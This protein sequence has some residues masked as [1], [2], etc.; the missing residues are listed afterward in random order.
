MIGRK[1]KSPLTNRF[2]KNFG[3]GKPMRK[4]LFVG[5]AL[6]LLVPY[7]G[8]TLAASVTITGSGGNT[9]I[10]FGQG[11]QVAINCDTSIIT[12][13]NQSWDSNSSAFTVGAIV[14]SDVNVTQNLTTT[15]NNGGCGGK[16]MTLSLY[17]GAAGS[18]TPAVIGNG[19]A[20]S[21]S[22]TV[23]TTNGTNAFTVNNNGTNGITASSTISSNN[24]TLTITLPTGLVTAANITRV[25]I[26]TDNPA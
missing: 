19:S 1:A 6:L 21:V 15:A 11:N 14:L 4:G 9:A 18:A 12:T 8:S 25:S 7:I 13:I 22:F 20:T 2:S 5:A 24:A 26:Q 10:E 16:L 3:G 23:P 17:T